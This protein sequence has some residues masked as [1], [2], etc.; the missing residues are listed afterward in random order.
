[1][2]C[3][4]TTLSQISFH[5][6]WSPFYLS[7]FLP[8][9]K[10]FLSL[11]FFSPISL[12]VFI[13]TIPHL[14]HCNTWELK[15]G[16]DLFHIPQI[17]ESTTNKYHLSSKPFRDSLLPTR[18]RASSLWPC[19]CQSPHTQLV[20]IALL[21]IP[22]HTQIHIPK[23][24]IFLQF[25]LHATGCFTHQTHFLCCLCILEHISYLHPSP[26]RYPPIP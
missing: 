8:T 15:A 20:F 16:L 1:M 10:Y 18:Q 25:P 22:H 5:H 26:I 24:S 13:L 11:S 12:L 4:F 7:Y 9:S 6:H 2:Y 21:S 14:K 17:E 3:V 23:L 19:S